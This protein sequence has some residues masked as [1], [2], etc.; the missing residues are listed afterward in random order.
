M[1]T[2]IKKVKVKCNVCDRETGVEKHVA[3]HG[4]ALVYCQHCGKQ[5]SPTFSDGLYIVK[6]EYL[7]IGR[8]V[9]IK[10]GFVTVCNDE[11]KNSFSQGNFFDVN[12]MVGRVD[13]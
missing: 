1:E 4:S 12:L 13:S 9:E 7:D 2:E 11:R 8:K 5:F 3:D 10:D 6:G